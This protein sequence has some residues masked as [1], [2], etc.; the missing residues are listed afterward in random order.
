MT[1]ERLAVTAADS[2]YGRQEVNHAR[3]I[4]SGAVDNVQFDVMRHENLHC[5]V[6]AFAGSNEL[7]D[8]GRH[9]FVRR[10]KI[11]GIGGLVHR[12]WLSDWRK[13]Q[14]TFTIAVREALRHN[15]DLLICG[16]SYGG[17]LAQLAAAT[18]AMQ[19]VESDRI[20][21]YTFGCPR[22]G[23][24]KFAQQ[25]DGLIPRHFRHTIK[26]DPVPHLPLGIRYKHAGMNVNH[27]HNPKPHSMASYKEALGYA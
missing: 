6:V 17:A 15:D 27:P 16:H 5:V 24:K 25:L 19:L 20:H 4:W 7:A 2:V 22:L 9:I 13:S 18:A 8:W 12:G 23:N 1:Y 21:L 14:S 10:R 3:V 26:S 11:A